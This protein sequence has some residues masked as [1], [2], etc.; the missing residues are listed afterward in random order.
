MHTVRLT[1]SGRVGSSSA[2]RVGLNIP[3]RPP[4]SNS[5]S[6]QGAILDTIAEAFKIQSRFN[7]HFPHTPDALYSAENVMMEFYGLQKILRA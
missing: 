1:S 4:S 5:V 3:Q 6:E 2:R 7:A